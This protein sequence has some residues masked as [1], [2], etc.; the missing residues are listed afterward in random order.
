MDRSLDSRQVKPPR[1]VLRCFAQHDEGQW[2]AVCVDFNLAAQAD[3]LREAKKKLEEQV[4]CYVRDALVGD[5]RAFVHELFNRKA[6]LSIMARYYAAVAATKVHAL[7]D[8]L[9][10]FFQPVPL[11]PKVCT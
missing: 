2:V 7:G 3:S 10:S 1:L 6:P 4:T 11:Q 9:V 5:D 8:T